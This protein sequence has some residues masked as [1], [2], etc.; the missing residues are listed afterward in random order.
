MHVVDV[1]DV[2]ETDAV[3]MSIGVET[4]NRG[5]PHHHRA[6]EN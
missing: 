5:F 6:C 2:R 3:Y 1:E 4:K